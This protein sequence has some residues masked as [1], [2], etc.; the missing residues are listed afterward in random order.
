MLHTSYVKHHLYQSCIYCKNILFI[1]NKI[2]YATLCG[3][4]T[5]LSIRYG[6]H[7]IITYQYN[8]HFIVLNVVCNQISQKLFHCETKI[9]KSLGQLLR[10]VLYR[11]IFAVYTCTFFSNIK[12][13]HF[14]VA[15]KMTKNLKNKIGHFILILFVITLREILI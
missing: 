7:V 13:K 5:I 9:V 10:L 8:M 14:N 15:V 6:Q 1:L 12:S 11:L 2:S 4:I 3:S